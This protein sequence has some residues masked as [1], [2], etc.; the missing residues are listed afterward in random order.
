MQE[1][2]AISHFCF[3][4]RH[5]TDIRASS[6]PKATLFFYKAVI[7]LLNKGFAVVLPKGRYNLS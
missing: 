2:S 1:C 6:H 4:Q 3:L 5:S 7:R